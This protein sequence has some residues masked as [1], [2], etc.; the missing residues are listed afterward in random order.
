M[1][2]NLGSRTRVIRATV[3]V[4][5]VIVT[6]VG[7]VAVARQVS[8]RASGLPHVSCGSAD[9]H[10]L[11]ASTRVLE[12]DHG[13]LDCFTAAAR[14]CKAAT[15]EVREMGVD[16]GTTYVFSIR[17][18]GAACQVTETS[19]AYSANFGGW[20]GP[21]STTQCRLTAVTL[22]GVELNCDGGDEQIP[23][24]VSM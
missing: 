19:Q 9:T 7:A 3:L 23:A 24:A 10:Q 5:A 22:A 11:G 12:A 2:R 21:V 13:A 6:A 16:T 18:G 8:P 17:P 4:C 1:W 20:E 14:A 15:L